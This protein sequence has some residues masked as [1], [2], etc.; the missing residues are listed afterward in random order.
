M[1]EW[2][3]HGTYTI[4]TGALFIHY[5]LYTNSQFISLFRI[6]FENYNVICCC[7]C[8][9]FLLSIRFLAFGVLIMLPAFYVSASVF[10]SRVSCNGPAASTLDSHYE[11]Q[12]DIFNHKMMWNEAENVW[13]FLLLLSILNSLVGRYCCRSCWMKMK[14]EDIES[15]INH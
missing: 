5:S 1:N 15:T 14:I 9:L 7:C 2:C 8:C 10:I 11:S 3:A 6:P 12:N 13:F 4:L